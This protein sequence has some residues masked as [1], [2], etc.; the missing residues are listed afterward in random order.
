MRKRRKKSPNIEAEMGAL[1]ILIGQRSDIVLLS[2]GERNEGEI[3]GGW[4][5]LRAAD[6]LRSTSPDACASALRPA[7]DVPY[8]GRHER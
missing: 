5:G 6:S 4:H 8:F 3:H 2:T 1:G 7:S